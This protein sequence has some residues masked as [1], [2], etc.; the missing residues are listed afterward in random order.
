MSAPMD[1]L[2]DETLSQLINYHVQS[3]KNSMGDQIRR[4]LAELSRRREAAAT[5]KIPVFRKFP[6]FR[7]TPFFRGLFSLACDLRI[8]RAARGPAD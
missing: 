8:T 7:R 6:R 4:A 3:G 2:S 1:D 5:E